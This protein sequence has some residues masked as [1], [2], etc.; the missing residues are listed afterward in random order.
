MFEV[1]VQR[2]IFLKALS[3]AQSVV[4][5]KNISEISSHLKLEASGTTITLTALD[6]TLSITTVI[7]AEIEENG[8][9]TLPVHTLYDIVRKFSDE[10]IKIRIDPTQPSMVEISSGYSVFHLPF[11]K[12]EKFPRID[13]GVFDC[14]FSIPSSSLQKIIEKNRHTI[15]QEDSRYH[16]NGIFFH[17]ILENNELRGTATDGHRLSSTRIPLPKDAKNMQ[18]IIVPRKTIFEISKMLPDKDAE[19][20]IE[21]S[22]SKIKFTID[23]LVIISKLID[24]DFP[25]YL[26]LI[27]YN[28]NLFFNLPSVELSRAVDRATT[29]LMEKSQ[30]IEFL[31]DGNQLEIKV[32]G[33]HQSLANEK[34]E[35]TGNMEQFKI[36]FN[37]KYILDIMSSVGNNANVEFRF[38]D[39]V[40]PALVQSKEDDK[41]DFVIMPMRA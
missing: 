33:E 12:A 20:I 6:N 31:I 24:A 1:T 18:A 39:Q 8:S 41:T 27:P 37:A 3:H 21:S 10:V 17:P 36:S 26:P 2:S 32:G 23:S 35:I 19:I 34:L 38:S 40:S 5:R 25:D 29:I 15:S 9:L 30:A 28:N 7:E 16:L 22:S 13:V 14:K 11:L 4:E